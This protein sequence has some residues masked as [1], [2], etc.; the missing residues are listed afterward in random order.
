[1]V[2]F[3]E[4]VNGGFAIARADRKDG[5][6]ASEGTKVRGSVFTGGSSDLAFGDVLAVRSIHWPLPS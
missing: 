1:V 3:H 4:R 5:E 2:V 6:F